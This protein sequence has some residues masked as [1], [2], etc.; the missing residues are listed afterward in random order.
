MTN[1]NIGRINHD[2]LEDI[3][4]ELAMS[5]T[6]VN[7]GTNFWARAGYEERRV[8]FLKKH[9]LPVEPVKKKK[10]VINSFKDAFQKFILARMGDNPEERA[11]VM[12][13]IKQEEV[14]REERNSPRKRPQDPS[15]PVEKTP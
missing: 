8:A 5:P 12:R 7:Q 4:N 14:E 10:N 15:S 6:R 2:D 9:G 13:A 1:F 3:A 11:A